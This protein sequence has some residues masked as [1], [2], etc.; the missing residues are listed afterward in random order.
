VRLCHTRAELAALGHGPKLVLA[1]LASLEAGGARQLLVEWAAN[2]A[3]L[4]LFPG[5]APVRPALGARP[6][7]AARARAGSAG[8][9]QVLIGI[10]RCSSGCCSSDCFT[11]A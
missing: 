8:L 11:S 7:A 4:V 3:S 2:P 9:Q 6:A 1:T 5:A 10:H